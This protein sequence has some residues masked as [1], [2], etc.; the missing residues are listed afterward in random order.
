ML[1]TESLVPRGAHPLSESAL[2]DYVMQVGHDKIIAKESK[3]HIMQMLEQADPNNKA[4]LICKK[5]YENRKQ[6]YKMVTVITHTV[7]LHALRVHKV[8]V[9]EECVPP[10]ALA[11]NSEL[12]AH[13]MRHSY[14]TRHPEV[15]R[16]KIW[17]CDSC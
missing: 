1:R 14:I 3:E 17:G 5:E 12:R 2:S 7:R 11:G 6:G 4:C 9:C 15:N 13:Q 16:R 8:R 10:L